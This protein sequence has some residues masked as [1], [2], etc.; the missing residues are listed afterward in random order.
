MK[1]LLKQEKLYSLMQ[2][3]EAEG[4]SEKNEDVQTGLFDA[5]N[6]PLNK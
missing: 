5:S 1:T 3:K 2:S 4:I 6:P